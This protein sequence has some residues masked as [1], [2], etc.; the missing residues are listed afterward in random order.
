MRRAIV[1]ILL[2]LFPWGIRRRCL[3]WFYGYQIHPTARIGK[4]I[5]HAEKLILHKHACIGN[6]C[7]CKRIDKLELFDYAGMGNFNYITGLPTSIKDKYFQH[8]KNRKCEVIIGRHSD[9]TSAHYLECTAGIYI[10]EFSLIAGIGSTIM[11]HSVDI[12]KSIQDAAPIHIGKYNFIGA[13][14]MIIKGV[15]TAD[16]VVTGAMSF[17]NKSLT[18]ERALYGGVPCK[19]VKKIE[20]AEYF[21]RTSGQI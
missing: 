3:K 12:Y 5:I 9:I 11:T 6:F 19:L 21:N 1:Q 13:K 14:N 7:L 10:G 20:N 15:V 8:I 2:W 17:I 18:E 16:F 4:S